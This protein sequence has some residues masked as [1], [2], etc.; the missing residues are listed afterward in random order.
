MTNWWERPGYVAALAF[1]AGA[2][3]VGVVLFFVL[4]GD[5]DDDGTRPEAAAATQ[6]ASAG[7]S[8]ETPA[9]R[10]TRGATPSQSPIST[11]TPAGFDDPDEALAA[12]VRDELDSEHIGECP[13]DLAPGEEPPTGICSFELYRSE[14]LV[15]FLLGV[16]LS[17]GIGEA[18]ITRHEDGSW[19]VEF[20]QAPPLGESDIAVGSQAV[21]FGAGDCLNFR[22][23][24]SLSAE[25]A[26]CRMDGTRGA[27]AEGPVDADGVTWWRLVDLGWASGEY[28]VPVSE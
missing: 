17:E 6:T 15:T 1:V 18:V 13:S 28:L 26:W 10:P 2:V 11:G 14:E 24:P 7:V 21:V 25:I 4:R 8:G 19:S 22:Q 12:F 3:V 9:A 5:G 20:I 23:A 16:P 27:V